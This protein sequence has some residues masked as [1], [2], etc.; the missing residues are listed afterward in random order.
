MTLVL[1]LSHIEIL[2]FEEVSARIGDIVLR[3]DIEAGQGWSCNDDHKLILENKEL[4]EELSK[5]NADVARAEAYL[6]AGAL[7]VS[8]DY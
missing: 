2:P 3:Y 5:E 1:S 7:V 4:D 6:H 8:L